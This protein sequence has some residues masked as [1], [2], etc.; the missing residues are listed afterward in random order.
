MFVSSAA[1]AIGTCFTG[2][3]LG[4]LVDGLAP[5]NALRSHEN[6]VT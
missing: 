5:E 4:D 6:T 3:V 1:S 2:C